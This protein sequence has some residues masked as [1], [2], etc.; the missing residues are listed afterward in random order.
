MCDIYFFL[1]INKKINIV[2]L[3][4]FF[5]LINIMVKKKNDIFSFDLLMQK[6][7]LYIDIRQNF[8]NE[9]FQNL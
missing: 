8:L 2:C 1:S 3:Y 7:V 4:L 6:M 5:F 9:K